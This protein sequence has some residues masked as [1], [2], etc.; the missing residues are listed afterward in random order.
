[1][2]TAC[3][4]DVRLLRWEPVFVFK[5]LHRRPTQIAFAV[6]VVGLLT[7][8]SV[9]YFTKPQ[10]SVRIT[11][12][13]VN[14]DQQGRF[15][16]SDEKRVD[17]EQTQP[18]GELDD[19]PKDQL[20]GSVLIDDSGDYFLATVT[21]HFGYWSFV[22]A[23][24]TIVLC[25][26][27]KDP[28]LALLSGVISGGMLL[29]QY[30]ITDDVLLPAIAS[31]GGAGILLLYLW[32]LGALMGI[33]SKT[34]AAEAF[35]RWATT[36]FVR[37]PKSA[38]LVAWILGVLFFQGGT[39]ST[40]LVGTTVKPVADRERISH[41]ELSYIVDSTASPIA[42]LLAFNAWPQYVQTLLFVPGIAYLATEESRTAFF[43]RSLPLSFYAWFAVLGTFL[44]SIDRAPIIGKR[45]RAAIKRAR[46]TGELDRPDADP[47]MSA[48][49]QKSDVPEGYTPSVAEFL[50]PLGILTAIAVGT[51]I[52]DGS[53]QV[54]VAFGVA[55]VVAAVSALFRGMTLKDLMDGVG[56]GLKG[57]VVASVILLLAV[58][59]GSV[60][61]QTGAAA[62]LVDLLGEAIPYWSM[63]AL[64][65]VLT[66]AIAFS[67]GT[68]W[69]TYAVAFPLAM[70]LAFSVAAVDGLTNPDLFVAICFAA[71]LNGSVMGDQCSPVSDTTVLS[72]MTTGAD[73]MDHVLTQIVPATAAGSLAVIGWTLLTLAC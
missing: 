58:A 20:D 13:E 21:D 39:I 14:E 48:E 33:W 1:M 24:M 46:E 72:S 45:M 47:M 3:P 12:L 73:L 19:L 29:S 50:L 2:A 43:F 64:L 60:T 59:L 9:G 36:H 25:L 28:L 17:V 63:P 61:Q 67:T 54:R 10:Q 16:V 18:L 65:F 55:A 23:V 66:V 27:L 11:A 22:P 35:A 26:T 34:G 40:V 41:E 6:V 49:L 71:V 51:F 15:Y 37:G 5:N 68:S 31:P 70:P 8:F 62:F 32:L 52:A 7:T 44:L 53:P 38:K 69:G 30:N 56:N 4:F 57:V 42:I